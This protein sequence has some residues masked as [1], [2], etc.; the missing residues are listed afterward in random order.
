MRVGFSSE[1]DGIVGEVRL[2]DL[3]R[4]IQ[5]ASGSGWKRVK[6]LASRV[7]FF[8]PNQSIQELRTQL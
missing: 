8:V 1:V 7:V 4:Q 5:S 3:I 6:N 2:E